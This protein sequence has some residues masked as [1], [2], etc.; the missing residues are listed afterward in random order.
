MANPVFTQASIIINNMVQTWNAIGTTFT[1]IKM[2]VTD[3]ASAAASKLIDLQV[4]AVSRF[5]VTKGGVV[6]ATRMLPG[7]VDVGGVLGVFTGSA[8]NVAV[9][10]GNAPADGDSL[11]LINAAATTGTV[12][13]FRASIS[14]SSSA[15]STVQ[16]NGAG[17]A[18]FEALVLGAGDASS[19]YSINGGQAWSVGLD[20]SASDSFKISASGDLGTSDVLTITTAGAATFAGVVKGRLTADNAYA[21]GVIVPTGSILIYDSN[22]TAYK[23]AVVAA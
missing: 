21:A 23:V 20:N 1:A 22:G 15:R 17:N 4:G 9:F 5:S 6:S 7:A 13:G 11:V 19:L 14:S 3:T 2:N 12:Y 18:T 16:Q 10:Q 8:G